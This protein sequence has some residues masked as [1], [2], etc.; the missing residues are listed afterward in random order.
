MDSTPG[1]MAL[2]FG[3]SPHHPS[4]KKGALGAFRS[5]PV[6]KS[7]NAIFLILSYILMLICPFVAIYHGAKAGVTDMTGAQEPISCKMS[8]PMRC[9]P[10]DSCGLRGFKCVPTA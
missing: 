8:F 1:V 7:F 6:G 9:E 5:S 3:V 4:Y 10:A 2:I